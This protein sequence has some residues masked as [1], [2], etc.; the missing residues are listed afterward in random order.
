MSLIA[1]VNKIRPLLL[2][3]HGSKIISPDV[4]LT[5][6]IVLETACTFCLPNV[7]HNKLWFIPI[8]TGYGISFYFFPKCLSKYSL[9]TAY[10]LWS[11]F[12]II[13]TFLLDIAL[14][15]EVFQIKKLIGILVVIY[16]ISMIK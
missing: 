6:S 9:S 13:F 5:S 1:P 12:G 10:T 16:G 8:Y 7:N 3:K 4:Y 15:R 14:K 2:I 11:G